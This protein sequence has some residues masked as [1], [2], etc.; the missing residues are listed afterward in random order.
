MIRFRMITRFVLVRI[1]KEKKKDDSSEFWGES[2]GIYKIWLSH[3]RRFHRRFVTRCSE[4]PYM[5]KDRPA[6]LLT[7]GTNNFRRGI[8]KSLQHAMCY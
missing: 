3:H 2:V 6:D 7:Y 5:M 8:V 1:F 4:S